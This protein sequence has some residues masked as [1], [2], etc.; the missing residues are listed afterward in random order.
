[1]LAFDLRDAL[2]GL[3]RDRPY[4]FITVLALALTIGATT[5]VFSIV[6]GV[7]LKPL[8]FRESERLVAIRE[9]W[10][11][12]SDQY[13]SLPVNEQHFEYWRTH[14][15]SFDSL[16]QYIRLPANLTGA[17]DA[18]QITLVHTSSSLFDVLRVRA[19]VGRTLAPDDDRTDRPEVVVIT[20]QL[21]RRLFDADRSLVGRSITLDGKSHLVV[22][23]LPADFRLPVTG[24]LTPKVDAFVPIRM[25]E[26]H[27]GWVGDHNNSAIGRLREDVTS[28]QARAELDVLQSQV[29]AIAT[30]E[31][32]QPVTL[33]SSVTPLSETI[34]GTARRGLLLLLAAIAAVLLIA[35]SNLANLSLTRTMGRLRE[36]AIRS[37]LG[38]GRSRLLARAV[39]EQLSLAIVGGALGVGVAWIALALFVRTA[40]IDLPR[41]NEV[42]LDARVVGFAAVVSLI[43]GLAVAILPALRLAHRD[44]EATLRAGSGTVTV[45]RHGMRT[46]AVL[47]AFQVGLSVTLLVVTALLTTS[48]VRLLNV[49]KGF[50]SDRVLAVDIALPAIRYGDESVRRA[51]YDRLLSAVSALPG[52]E[53]VS[54]TSLLPL[55][56]E[57]QVN[58]IEAEGETRPL[59]EQPTANFRIV[60][61][62]FFK[63]LSIPVVRG[64]AF[65]DDERDAG[66]AAPAVITESTAARL[67]PGEDAIGKRFSRG[68]QAEQ[69]FEVVGMVANARTTALDQAPPMMVYVPYWWQSRTAVSMLIRTANDPVVLMPS[70]RRAIHS[71]DLEIAVGQFRPLDDV[72]NSSLAGRRYQMRL[73]MAFGVVALLIAALGVYAV[74]MYGASRRRREMNIR[75]ALG[76]NPRQV[77]GLVLR[78]GA[79]PLAAG[80]IVGALAAA[81]MGTVVAS[82]LFDVRARDPLVIGAVT[83]LVGLVGA[84][85]LLVAARQSLVID[86]A[87]ALRDE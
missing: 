73:F 33:G 82:L 65:R 54:T 84:A 58:F 3:I 48:F 2:R 85:A 26:D 40:P 70:V 31:A 39:L 20:S 21:W 76:A 11:Q 62:E 55:S 75:V 51:A 10:R 38:A 22:G 36:M 42:A 32:H 41:V 50:S 72:V 87:S 47:L 56:G 28:E 29:S 83:A 57:G 8:A 15:R 46:R 77:L 6:N 66:R 27:V 53:G 68:N 80:I 74:T 52:V 49:D 34:V 69:G 12:F 64:R 67:W 13:G 18:V 63:T 9:I 44:L 86:P 14:A 30:K 19:A 17:G 60:A 37:A 71:I 5:A 79:T 45:D 24:Q 81:G 78:Q 23:V 59:S 43:A 4:S 25:D 61:P 7:L 1:M 16:A 35:C